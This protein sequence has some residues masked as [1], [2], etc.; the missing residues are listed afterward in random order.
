MV[1]SFN[2]RSLNL[3]AVKFL[4]LP[5]SNTLEPLLLGLSSMRSFDDLMIAYSLPIILLTFPS[6]F[7]SLCL[8]CSML[9][10]IESPSSSEGASLGTSSTMSSS[11]LGALNWSFF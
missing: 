10:L 7:D 4:K 8:D 1:P 9:S 6:C 3:F 5:L 2:K 11:S